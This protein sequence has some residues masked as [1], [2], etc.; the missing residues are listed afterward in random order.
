MVLQTEGRDRDTRKLQLRDGAIYFC[1]RGRN[2]LER[3]QADA[4]Q[5]RTL[6]TKIGDPVVVTAAKGSG[7][8]F[9]RA[10]RDAEGA[11]GK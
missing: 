2:V 6:F 9:L 11:G 8:I 4:F 3:H 10:L 7:V 1:H 5:A